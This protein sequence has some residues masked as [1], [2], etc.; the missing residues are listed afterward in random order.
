M[1]EEQFTRLPLKNGLFV[2]TSFKDF[3]GNRWVQS[4][5]PL[6]TISY[7][8]NLKYSADPK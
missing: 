2:R 5:V 1:K 3:K 6:S 7:C 4:S 8:T